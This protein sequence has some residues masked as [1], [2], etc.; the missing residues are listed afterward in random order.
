MADGYPKDFQGRIDTLVG[1]HGWAVIGGELGEDEPVFAHSI[2][3]TESYDHP[4]IMIVGFEPALMGAL[5]N[6]AGKLVSRGA[7]LVDGAEADKILDGSRVAF[8]EI[9]NELH[10]PHTSV[11]RKRYGRRACGVLQM[12]LP[13]G[14]GLYP[15]DE[16]C[17]PEV[18]EYQARLLHPSDG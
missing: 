3:L 8:R 7:R 16:G 17:D 4:E 1:E 5:I 15:W 6:N 10:S 12:F 18:A 2:G 9:P 11:L 13:D 14:D